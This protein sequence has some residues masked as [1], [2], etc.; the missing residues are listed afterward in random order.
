MTFVHHDVSME[1]LDSQ[2]L[3]Q[4]GAR[5]EL[6]VRYRATLSDQIFDVVSL[7]AMKREGGYWKISSEKIQ[8]FQIDGPSICTPSRY[9]CL[10]GTCV[11]IQ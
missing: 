11:R 6:A 5:S 4:S 9:A 7:V 2:I 1:I 10:G 8:E 3:K